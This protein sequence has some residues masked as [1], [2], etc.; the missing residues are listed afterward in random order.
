MQTNQ[1]KIEQNGERFLRLPEVE[2]RTSQKKSAI[3][4]GMKTGAFPKNLKTGPRSSAWLESE[5]NA[6]IADR[7]RNARGPQ[8]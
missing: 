1:T 3:Y 8:S 6:W 7:V 2:F 4:A 5:I